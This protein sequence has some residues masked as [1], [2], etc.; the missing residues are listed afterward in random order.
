VITGRNRKK[1]KEREREKANIISF[2]EST[3]LN[4]INT[5]IKRLF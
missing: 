4:S 3:K 5:L 1:V 2:S